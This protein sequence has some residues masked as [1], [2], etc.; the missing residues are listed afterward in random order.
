L[1]RKEI[2]QEDRIYSVLSGIS[3]WAVVN[4]T[5][6]VVGS[7]I[8]VASLLGFYVWQGYQDS[9]N[10]EAQKLFAEALDT[11]TPRSRNWLPIP[12]P[13]VKTRISR[14][15][16]RRN[17]VSTP[18]RNGGKLPKWRSREYQTT[19]PAL[20]S[21]SS[22]VITWASSDARRKTPGQRANT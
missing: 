13:T 14:L 4:R 19:F 3:Q 21:D 9:A 15:S 7:G 20:V 11:T 10:Q 17:T 8:V 5:P 1:T 16:R 12:I 18:L 2:V 6:L 22:P